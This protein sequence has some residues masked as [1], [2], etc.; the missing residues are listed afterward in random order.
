MALFVLVFYN[1]VGLIRWKAHYIHHFTGP[2]KVLIPLMF[3]L[4]VVSH[5]RARFRFLSVFSATSAVKKSL[6]CCSS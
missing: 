2:S 6:W 1:A 3:P 4:E 5:L